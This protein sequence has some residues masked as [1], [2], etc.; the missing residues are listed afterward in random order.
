MRRSNWSSRTSSALRPTFTLGMQRV[1]WPLLQVPR[2]TA[3]QTAQG[4]YGSDRA[5]ML[6]RP[7]SLWLRSAVRGQTQVPVGG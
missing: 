6:H 4:H 1:P 2:V 5:C 7:A 3:P